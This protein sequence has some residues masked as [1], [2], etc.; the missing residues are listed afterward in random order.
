[1]NSTG[2]FVRII[3]PLLMLVSQAAYAA[4]AQETDFTRLLQEGEADI[5]KWNI[6]GASGKAETAIGLADTDEERHDAYYLKAVTEYYRGNYGAAREYAEKTLKAVRSGEKGE[7]DGFMEFIQHSVDKKPEFKEVKSEHFTIRYA[8]PK[9]YII[10][11]YG[12]DVLEKSRFE[13]GLDLE[14]YPGEP[15][16]VEIYPDLESFTVAS[17]LPPENVEK[18]GV[19]GICKFNRIMILSP[20]LLP[21]GYSWSDTLAHEYTHYLIFLKS[22]NTVP[23]WLH[24]GIAKFEE[25]RWREE[26]RNVLSPF[27]ETILAQAIEKDGLVPIEKMHPSLALLDSAREAQLAFAQAGTSVSFL[28]DRWGNEG[29]VG[30]LE[31]MKARDDYKAALAD[32]TGLDFDTFYGSWKKYLAGKNLAE[33]IPGVK[34]KGIRIRNTEGE[35]GDGSEDLVDIDNGKARGHTRLGD[36]LSARGR[37][38]GASY[39]YEKALGFDP[40]S[41]LISTRLASALNGSG[42]TDRALGILDPLIEFYPENVD[43]HLVLGRIYIGQGNVRKAEESYLAAVSIN[44]FDP[45]VHTALAAIYEK[46]GRTEEAKRERKVLDILTQKGEQHE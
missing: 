24:E 4:P 36:L 34:V 41:P 46:E 39:E 20:R 17:T 7:E 28:V 6:S 27:Y 45:E 15:V 5:R 11:E 44:P 43:I 38:R 13:I 19:V 30:L 2:I 8:N 33:K 22:E 14:E 16:I 18:T 31:A 40:G 10:A 37:L 1:M 32:V 29:L 25:S 9:D 3:V 42:E 23:V 21:K 12:K 26:K 35:K